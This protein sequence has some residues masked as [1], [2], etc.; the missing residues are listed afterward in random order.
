ML[1]HSEGS[2]VLEAK[3]KLIDLKPE[4]GSRKRA[5]RLG[6]G[7]ASGKGNTC[8]RGD[9][10]QGQ[11][12][13]KGARPGFEGGQTPLFRRLPKYQTNERSNRLTWAIVNLKQLAK[14]SDC[15]EITAQLLLDKGIID[16]LEDG[17]RVLGSGEISFACTIKA[18]HFTAQAKEKIE[19]AGGKAEVLEKPTKSK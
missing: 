4:K 17:L 7:R 1:L 14:L 18:N 8:C 11:R 6:R 13:G 9:D 2:I 16:K 15:K 5:K 10:G 12:A 3:M 19:K